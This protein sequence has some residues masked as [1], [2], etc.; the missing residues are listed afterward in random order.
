[1]LLH[2]SGNPRL[3][4]L[5]IVLCVPALLLSAPGSKRN[6]IR[7][8]LSKG[9]RMNGSSAKLPTLAVIVVVVFQ[10]LVAALGLI[11]F[12]R[13]VRIEIAEYSADHAPAGRLVR[14]W[15]IARHH[16]RVCG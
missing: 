15:R 13:G 9:R 16:R 3:V 1:M 11:L 4:L 10:I 12:A 6:L 2:S 8:W 5:E 14:F 7:F